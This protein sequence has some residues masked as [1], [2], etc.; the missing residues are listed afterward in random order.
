M[1]KALQIIKKKLMTEKRITTDALQKLIK[2]SNLDN[3]EKELLSD[4]IIDHNIDLVD[5]F[6]DEFKEEEHDATKE[7][8][9]SVE[10]VSEE[11]LN[12]LS[13]D[14][15]DLPHGFGASLGY[16][17]ILDDV[18]TIDDA[19]NEATLSMRQAKEKL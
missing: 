3:E 10:E 17:M 9:E 14:L 12:N 13:K 1:S 8:L 16:S 15:K 6:E 2:E 11:E 5:D 18:K 7:D 4:F 19:I